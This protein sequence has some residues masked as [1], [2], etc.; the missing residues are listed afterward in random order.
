MKID[1]PLDGA[2]Q[3]RIRALSR[4]LF[5]SKYALEA[6]VLIALEERFFQGQISTA[7]GCGANQ[8]GE[9]LRRLEHGGLIEPL[10]HEP[11]QT[12]KYFR[13]RPSPVWDFCTTLAAAVMD[14][15][16]VPVARL[17]RRS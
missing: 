3:A 5:G 13:R 10:S 8:I 6:L 16:E 17:P 4:P 7:T 2:R 14:E 1:L 12:R 9:L 15:P 11:G